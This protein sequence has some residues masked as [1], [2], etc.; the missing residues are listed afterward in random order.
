MSVNISVAL[1]KDKM[2]DFKNSNFVLS[3]F[4]A[5][6]CIAYYGSSEAIESK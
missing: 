2:Y 4:T 6:Y 3:Y 5:D 1:Q